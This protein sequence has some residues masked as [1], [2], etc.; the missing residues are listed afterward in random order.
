MVP[1]IK[2]KFSFIEWGREAWTRLESNQVVWGNYRF[3]LPLLV[4]FVK[5][6]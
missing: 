1:L 5:V 6:L 3:D 4:N 2:F